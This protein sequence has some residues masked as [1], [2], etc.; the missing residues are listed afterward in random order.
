MKITLI[1]DELLALDELWY[2]MKPYETLHTVVGFKSG[3]EALADAKLSSPDIVISD[4]RMP[5]LNGLKV[6]EELITL[7]PRTQAIMLSGYNDFEY[8]RI[9]MKFGAKEYL[10]KPVLASD[11]YSVVDRM[12]AAVRKEEEKSRLEL[13]WSLSRS[14]RGILE[15]KEDSINELTGDWLLVVILL[16]NWNSFYLWAHSGISAS[17]ISSWLRN[18]GNV[19]AECFDMDEHLRIAMWP[20]NNQERDGVL[21][22]RVNRLYEYLCLQGLVVH[23]VYKHRKIPQSLAGI[24]KQCLNQLEAQLCL[25]ESTFMQIEQP[26]VTQSF[27]DSA[28]RIEQ[29]LREQDYA[30]F[31]L[32]LRRMIEGLQRARTTLK[33]TSVLLVDFLYALKFKL[34]DNQFVLDTA[35]S[36]SLYEVLKSCREET[37]L[38]EWLSSKL[39]SLMAVREKKILEPKQIIPSLMEYAQQHYGEVVHLQDFATKHHVSISYLS[40]LFKTETGDNFSDYIIRLRINKARELL[41]NG[42]KRIA[43]IGKLVGYEDPKFFSQT[44]KRWTG[45]TPQEYKRKNK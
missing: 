34:N 20:L 30:K 2:L 19:D 27:W 10:L 25:G 14:I 1:E 7:Q 15:G 24:Y 44:F 5:G 40:K 13:H 36:D 12:I 43:E 32:E 28:R 18:E 4:I 45:V 23:C 6:V 31:Q 22:Q 17:D 11:L 16:E 41:D 39:V 3:E 9:A 38:V 26:V 33:Q 29:H 37:M 8:A 35:G 21:R 42:Y